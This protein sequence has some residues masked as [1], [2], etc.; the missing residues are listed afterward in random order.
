MRHPREM[1]GS[2]V[3]AFLQYLANQRRVSASTHKQAPRNA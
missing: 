1:E 3:E 2:H